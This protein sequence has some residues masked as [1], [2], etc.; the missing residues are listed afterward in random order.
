MHTLF[1]KMQEA[2]WRSQYIREEIKNNNA[3]FNSKKNED[4]Y[5]FYLKYLQEVVINADQYLDSLED[6]RTKEAEE[7][8]NIIQDHLYIINQVLNQF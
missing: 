6:H 2:V 3:F 4:L 7:A 5:K 1:L 8:I